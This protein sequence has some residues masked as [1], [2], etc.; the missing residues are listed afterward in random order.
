[1][2]N[3]NAEQM[4]NYPPG[5]FS[6]MEREGESFYA[7][8]V[9]RAMKEKRDVLFSNGRPLHAVYLIY[10]FF[11]QARHEVRLF[12]G[13]LL[14]RVPPRRLDEGLPVYE[15][16]SVLGA[17][18]RFLSQKDTHLKVVL[19]NDLDVGDGQGA[20]DHPL[21]KTV[22]DLRNEGLLKG[23]CDIEQ[24]E[25]G[26]IRQLQ[27]DD[28]GH[29]MVLMDQ[30][31]YR[32]ET[33]PDAAEALVNVNDEDMTKKLASFYDRKLY[34]KGD[35]LWTSHSGSHGSQHYMSA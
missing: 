2:D 34:S 22:I 28:V 1:M 8:Y 20:E 19:A 4:I 27:D 31:A 7:D 5:I 23:R 18:R 17:V 6:Y 15:N 30:S 16:G 26:Y 33:G 21:V 25:A 9:D 3:D 11:M 10:K 12:S 14:R 32:L 24:L 35:V 29:H 13:Q